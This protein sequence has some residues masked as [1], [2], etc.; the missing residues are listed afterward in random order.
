MVA[1]DRVYIRNGTNTS[2]KVGDLVIQPYGFD[3]IKLDRPK[4]THIV[5]PMGYKMVS[6][7]VNM[8]LGPYNLIPGRLYTVIYA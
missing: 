8:G 5:L 4:I 1:K 3:I 7:S 6:S 2:V